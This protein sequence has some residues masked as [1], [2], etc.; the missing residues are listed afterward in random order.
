M[1]LSLQGLGPTG[2]AK[3]QYS[4]ARYT[5][6]PTSA[7]RVCTPTQ[8]AAQRPEPP[9]LRRRTDFCANLCIGQREYRAYGKRASG[10]H[11]PRGPRPYHVI[12]QTRTR[13]A[14]GADATAVMRMPHTPPQRAREITCGRSNG[15]V[16]WSANGAR[17]VQPSACMSASA[18]DVGDEHTSERHMFASAG[19]GYDPPSQPEL[20][21][22]RPKGPDD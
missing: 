15:P 4:S 19:C 3:V 14:A 6:S 9:S 20:G 7:T 8:L 18:P 21:P 1:A 17:S 16:G 10:G 5:Q 2:R 11:P 13:N 22:R 12:C